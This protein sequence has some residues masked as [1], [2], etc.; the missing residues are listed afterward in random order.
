VRQPPRAG[1]VGTVRAGRLA[2]QRVG[3]QRG[4]TR[5]AALHVDP[6]DDI[7]VPRPRRRR[8]RGTAG[9]HDSR[10][11]GCGGMP[12]RNGSGFPAGRIALLGPRPRVSEGSGDSGLW[13]HGSNRGAW[14]GRRD[15]GCKGGGQGDQRNAHSSSINRDRAGFHPA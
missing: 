9:G 13:R 10:P 7:T 11:E 4:T 1:H 3:S 12:G 14:G 2:Q 15:Q 6:A 8:G 5:P